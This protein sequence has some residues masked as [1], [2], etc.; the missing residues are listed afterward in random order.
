MRVTV[1]GFFAVVALLVWF[2]GDV[3]ATTW[4]WTDERGVVHFSDNYDNIP[5]SYREKVRVESEGTPSVIPRGEVV[6]PP[7]ESAPPRAEP[8]KKTRA[9]DGRKPKKHHHHKHDVKGPVVTLS[10]A[11][12]AQNQAEEQIR[13]DRQ[14][15]DDAQL[16]A[17]KAQ[18]QSEE[19]IRKAR[20]GTMGH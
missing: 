20:E 15:I 9:A 17:R 1:K 16:P 3:A 18:E 12:L 7:Q 8:V 19:Q 11:R 2:A 5:T 6:Q 14:A 4:R 13:R 10:P